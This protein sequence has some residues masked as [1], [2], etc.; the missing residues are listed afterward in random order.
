MQGKM[1]LLLMGMCS[2]GTNGNEKDKQ[3]ATYSSHNSK[4]SQNG[5]LAVMA[6]WQGTVKAPLT[7][8]TMTCDNQLAAAATVKC[9]QHGC[10][11]AMKSQ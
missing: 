5:C 2:S 4:I 3:Q 10:L 7:V 8:M 6:L 11:V 9:S 1:K